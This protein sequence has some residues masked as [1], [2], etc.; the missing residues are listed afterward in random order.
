M[1]EASFQK[2]ELAPPWRTLQAQLFAITSPRKTRQ[3]IASMVTDGQGAALRH[4]DLPLGSLQYLEIEIGH[5]SPLPDSAEPAFLELA[6]PPPP[7]HIFEREGALQ[8]WCSQLLQDVVS[9]EVPA[10]FIPQVW[11]NDYAIETD[12]R[13]P[14]DAL[15]ELSKMTAMEVREM[16]IRGVDF[17]RLGNGFAPRESH[18]GPFEIDVDEEALVRLVS[19][20]SGSRTS[21][22]RDLKERDWS[23]F[24]HKTARILQ[25]R[26]IPQ[27]DRSVEVEGRCAE[28]TQ[29]AQE[30]AASLVQRL[31]VALNDAS[32]HV[33]A[34]KGEA[35]AYQAD[36]ETAQDFLGIPRA[37]SRA[38]SDVIPLVA[39]EMAATSPRERGG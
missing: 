22:V 32:L 7:V 38:Q 6:V 23:R 9:C 10:V 14:F 24:M 13:A 5:K 20:F 11:V 3:I 2:P 1:S 36:L 31:Y 8:A 30:Q 17:D 16:F 4:F 39:P 25:E 29:G 27:P 18:D 12:D 35:F 26:R 33:C 28:E 15:P 21:A 37:G 34:G 19:L